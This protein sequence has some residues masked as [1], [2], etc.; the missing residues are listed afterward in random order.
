MQKSTLYLNSVVLIFECLHLLAHTTIMWNHKR[1]FQQLLGWTSL[2]RTKK[3]EMLYFGYSPI[4]S[5]LMVRIIRQFSS[6]QSF[7]SFLS[8]LLIESSLVLL[9][10]LIIDIE[11]VLYRKDRLRLH[12]SHVVQNILHL[13]VIDYTDHILFF[14]YILYIYAMIWCE[15]SYKVCKAVRQNF[16]DSRE[17]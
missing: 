14:A 17:V 9:I 4:H 2:A 12:I 7:F 16:M 6:W 1:T 8:R 10:A 3:I 5:W 15:L 11:V 13:T